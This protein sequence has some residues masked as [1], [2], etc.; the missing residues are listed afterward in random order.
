M[1]GQNP[2]TRDRSAP[3]ATVDN[4]MRRALKIADP[5]NPQQVAKGLLTLYPAEAEK[6]Q[7]EISGLPFTVLKAQVAAVVPANGR[8]RPEVA[9]ASTTLEAALT[10]LTTSPDLAGIQ[11]E[12][13][14]WAAMIR[15]AWADGY[16]AAAFAID[17]PQRDEAFGARRLLNELARLARYAAAVSSCAADVYCRVANACDRAANI[18]LVMIGDALGNAG[19]GRGGAILQVSAATLEI[20]KN[21]VI[22]SLRNL[23]SP[24]DFDDQD[25]FPHAQEAVLR[26]YDALAE[27]GSPDLRTVLDEASLAR[28]LDDLIDNV[29]GPTSEGLR[30]LGATAALVVR[31]L[32]RFLLIVEPIVG[33][34][35]PPASVF[36]AEL[37]LFTQGFQ[38]T[39]SG[40]RL[41]YLA[42]PPLLISGS[43]AAAGID[44]PT[45]NLLAIALGRTALADQVDCLCCSCE[46]E[47]AVELVLAAKVLF[48]IDRAIDLY[49]L[50][51]HPGGV[52]EAEMRAGAYG[53]IIQNAVDNGFGTHRVLTQQALDRITDFLP[54]IGPGDLRYVE[55]LNLQV[56]DE[57]RWGELVSSIA[58]SCRQDLLFNSF[59]GA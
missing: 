55:I 54:A 10:E 15:R 48:D 46:E 20:R 43:A 13:G 36:F 6:I 8:G 26:I 11:P 17:A 39:R 34:D 14:A 3:A 22:T 53:A 19:V 29:S 1:N 31:R 5:R 2:S 9:A 57:H 42:C 45:Q 21:G 44:I 59:T 56:A 38:S 27:A 24:V 58:P 33:Q 35:S 52:G 49:G 12:L 40:Y 16:A 47:D 37:R 50:G 51:T 32:E 7:R 28:Q 41:T 23:L 25:A 4:L 18:I 30:A